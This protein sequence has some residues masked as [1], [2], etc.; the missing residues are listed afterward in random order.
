MSNPRP[1]ALKPRAK[2]IKEHVG[3]LGSAIVV[4]ALC[5]A[6][7]TSRLGGVV[8]RS[9]FA[10]EAR[11][12]TGLSFVRSVQVSFPGTAGRP[13]P[14]GVLSLPGDELVVVDEDRGRA[15]LF[16]E[17]GR[18]ISFLE[19]P[20]AFRAS[21]A[22][23]GPGLGVY[24]MDSL[25]SRVYRF[26]SLGRLAGEA[27][28]ITEE[29]R[30]VDLCLDKLGTAY[31]SDAENDEIIVLG[32]G[33]GAQGRLGGLGTQEGMFVDPA[34]LAVDEQN[35]LYVCDAGNSRVQVLDQWG[36][37]VAVWPIAGDG[38]R[39]RPRAIALDRWGNAFITD[40]GCECLRVV[41]AAGV[42]TFRLEGSGPG[43]GFTG[44]PNGLD[45]HRGKLFVADAVEGAIQVFDI[46]YE[47]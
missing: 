6:C 3:K 42:E 46:T 11:R 30:F 31:L 28:A 41:D 18:F 20:G 19:A 35:R 45:V 14:S 5:G 16:S 17:D 12:A 32:A 21:E 34:G 8:E 40:Q 1:D 29:S 38:C 27:F 37:V 36:A 2:L 39:P 22:A 25:G 7:S 23:V 43:L 13:S 15:G 9:S 26:D 44:N 10:G 4:A 24:L 47:R 33:Y